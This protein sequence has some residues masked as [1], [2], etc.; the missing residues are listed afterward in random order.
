MASPVEEI[1][2]YLQQEYP[3]QKYYEHFERMR[4]VDL[5]D[6]GLR[7]FFGEDVSV[8]DLRVNPAL[9]KEKA[10]DLVSARLEK[11]AHKD[12]FREAN[13]KARL[14]KGENPPRYR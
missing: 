1:M 13:A 5:R 14:K 6:L 4:T 2:T 8:E 12:K 7:L 10:D 3:H 11:A 9:V